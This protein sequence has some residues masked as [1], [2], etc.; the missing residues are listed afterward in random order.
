[1]GLHQYNTPM[2][3]NPTLRISAIAAF[4]VVMA[5]AGLMFAGCSTIISSA[6]SG[7][8]NNLS[9]AILNQNDPE[10]VR[11][12]APAYLL[13]MDSFVEGA[14]DNSQMLQA[15]AKLY[16]MYGA[17]FTDDPI[18]AKRLTKRAW[19]YGQRALCAE[20]RDGCK[21]D[22]L[23]FDECDK[24]LAEL[25]ANDVPAL[26]AFS[27]SWLTYL[28][29]HSDDWNALANLPKAE[30]AIN[31]LYELDPDFEDGTI[32]LYLGILATLRPPA[33]GGRPEEGKMRFEK[34]IELTAGRNLT[35]L[36]EYAK[37]Y[38][39]MM[40]DRELH[41]RLLNQVL[42]ADPNVSGL[43]LFNIIAQREALELLAAADD[44][45]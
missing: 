2:E 11:D 34:A 5:A 17:V 30:S 3:K 15:A 39:R 13:M 21:L 38:A 45:F 18:R 16:A 6:T 26:F 8:A 19:G 7:M 14:P 31:R 43:T 1:M 41:D 12:G 28:R 36:V 32:H 33:L 24:V 42:E 22:A 40:Y 20:N 37:S 25:G 29:A 35:V 44:Y 23:G 4:N 27:V 9:T 10:T